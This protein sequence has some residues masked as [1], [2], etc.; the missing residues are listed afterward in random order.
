MDSF[1]GYDLYH[2]G[3]AKLQKVAQHL[4]GVSSKNSNK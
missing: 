3:N 4:L 2:C 1:S